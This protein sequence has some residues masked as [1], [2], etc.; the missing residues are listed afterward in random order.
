TFEL[1]VLVGRRPV[2]ANG[3]KLVEEKDQRTAAGEIEDLSQVGGSLAKVRRH[4][5]VKAHR[6]KRK[7]KFAGKS[8]GCNRLT[9]PR[10]ST[11][12]DLAD[13]AD[14]VGPEKLLLASFED[15][16]FQRL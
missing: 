8:L 4:H 13:G 10:R 6:G 12:Q 15:D 2:L 5:G 16:S 11:K 9:A 14:A 7:V 3:V 1:P